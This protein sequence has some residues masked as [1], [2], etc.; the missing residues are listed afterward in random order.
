MAWVLSNDKRMCVVCV[1]LSPVT[2]HLL[3]RFPLTL[4]YQ[5]YYGFRRVPAVDEAFVFARVL[6]QQGVEEE[7][8]VV[9]L[10]HNLWGG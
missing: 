9:G 2:L 3:G 8:K 6:R 10:Q 4:N 7:P 5:V 1:F